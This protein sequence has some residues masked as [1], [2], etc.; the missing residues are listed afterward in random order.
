MCGCWRHFPRK[1]GAG[2]LGDRF[3]HFEPLAF[4]AVAARRVAKVASQLAVGAAPP[5]ILNL[6]LA[7]VLTGIPKKVTGTRVIQGG[8]PFAAMWPAR[9]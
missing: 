4:D 6:A 8:G 1:S 5:D 3:E 2:P 9:R 7:C